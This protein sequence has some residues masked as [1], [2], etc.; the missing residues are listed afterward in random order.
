MIW[1]L[2]FDDGRCL[3]LL[4]RVVIFEK[5]VNIAHI[6]IYINY[7]PKTILNKIYFQK[8]N[9]LQFSEPLTHKEF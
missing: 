1:E 8:N 7:S 5:N 9:F 2:E 3:L 6:I 4:T